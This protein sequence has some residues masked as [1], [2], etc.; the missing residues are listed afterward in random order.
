MGTVDRF[1]A[2]QVVN[3]GLAD[4]G[5]VVQ[6]IQVR[7]PFRPGPLGICARHVLLGNCENGGISVHFHCTWAFLRN[8]SWTNIN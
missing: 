2:L 7:L 5:I 1:H 8:F 6:A 3:V 4:H